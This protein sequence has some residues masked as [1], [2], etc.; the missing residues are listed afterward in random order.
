MK[1]F[2]LFAAIVALGLI[3]YGLY[4]YFLAP[5]DNFRSIYL[6]PK[7]AVYIIQT[8]EPIKSWKKVSSS[9]IWQHMQQQ[10]YFAELTSS[11]NS[12]DSTIRNNEQ[13]FDILGSRSITVSA[14]VYAPRKYD[15]LFI[16]D[17]EKA[18]KLNFVQDYFTN[19]GGEGYLITSRAHRGN[20][21]YE[22]FD[23]EDKSTLYLTFIRNL[24]VCSYVN[25]LVEASINQQDEP[26]IGRDM[27]FIEMKQ[28]VDEDGLFNIYLQYSGLDDLMRCYLAEE[29]EYINALSKS[30]Y[31]TGLNVA[32]DD[33]DWFSMKGVTNINDSV[34]SYLKAMLLSG[35]GELNAQKV[36]P[37]RTAFYM[38]LAVDNFP[39]FY[40]NFKALLK[41]DNAV[42]YAEYE[43]NVQQIEKFLK[44]SLQDNFIKWIGNEVAFVQSQPKGL[45]K[46]NEFA[47]V[48]KSTDK[49]EAITNL[50]FIARQIRKKTPVKF[51][52]IDYKGYPINFL[53]VKGMF[54]VILGNFFKKLDKPYYTII[55]D[56]VVFSNHP[57]TI[58]NFIDDYVTERTLD[59][60][61]GFNNF[62]NE[63]NTASNIFI[64]V[65]PPILHDNLKGFVSA[66]TWANVKKNK[67]YIV[68]YPHIGFQ[69][70]EKNSMF[71]TQFINTFKA[72][73]FT[74][75]VTPVAE[76]QSEASLPGDTLH[77]EETVKEEEEESDEIYLEDL[78][79]KKHKETYA[80]GSLKLEVDI[81][82][83]VKH[84][85]YTEYY[86]DGKTKIK[87]KYRN[88][89]KHG[90]FKYYDEEGK[91]KEKREYEEGEIA[92]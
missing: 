30:L 32:L 59:K 28:Q 10:P 34:S 38:S 84:G 11:A 58:K 16:V 39:A 37:Q 13:L 56:Y 66:E 62:L 17:L 26:V 92:K 91:L 41:E 60:S 44:I 79:V 33:D 24:L 5:S 73:V 35:K 40:D 88:D 81:R 8:N 31:Y 15:F 27:H 67:D 51:K 12:L 45:G 47:V 18:S 25:Q 50:N 6:V 49:E 52:E 90:T 82:N 48:I 72:P 65:H 86:P 19:L 87:G 83:G 76:Q 54:K 69:M 80:D 36:I 42:E 78:D 2:L 14:H 43:K 70:N 85:N 53:S 3:A 55:D 61:E 1:K 77:E 21:I 4:T 7:D 68:C 64:Y 22:L 89:Q 23:K 46:E 71:E 29:D 20:R 9:K 75:E 63:F 74:E 57:Q